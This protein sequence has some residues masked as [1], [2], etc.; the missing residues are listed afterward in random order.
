[1][2][3]IRLR[4]IL[5]FLADHN[6]WD[7]KRDP[8]VRK[9]SDDLFYINSRQALDVKL[10]GDSQDTYS[11]ELD[12]KNKTIILHGWNESHHNGDYFG[13]TEVSYPFSKLSS[14]WLE[15]IFREKFLLH[16]KVEEE[17]RLTE[18]RKIAEEVLL[19]K[20]I[21]EYFKE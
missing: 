13:H 5:K 3:D 8:L 11:V 7:Y 20:K 1:M 16:I 2:D 4:K 9:K 6:G 10:T 17:K 12:L 14:D 18:A 19:N 15:K 21:Q